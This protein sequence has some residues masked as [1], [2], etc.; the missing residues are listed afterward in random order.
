MPIYVYK[1]T[2]TGETVEIFHSMKE[3]TYTTYNNRPVQKDYLGNLP[4]TIIDSTVPKTV[5]AL[6]AK[7]TEDMMRRGDPRVKSKKVEQPWW[8]QSKKALNVKGW[9]EKDKER[10]IREGKKKS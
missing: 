1:Y 4:N 3:P 7:N 10:Y 8:R 2:D 6:A 9:S 5:G